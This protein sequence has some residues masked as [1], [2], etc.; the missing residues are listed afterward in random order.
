MFKLYMD[1][2]SMAAVA[3]GGHDEFEMYD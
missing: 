3:F 2:D 1:D